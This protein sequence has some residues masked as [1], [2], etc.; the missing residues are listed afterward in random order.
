MEEG[1]EG[2]DGE[3]GEE[4]DAEV[5]VAV[6]LAGGV[7]DFAVMTAR[8]LFLSYEATLSDDFRAT[9]PAF[10]A[11]WVATAVGAAPPNGACTTASWSGVEVAA[12]V[13][14]AAAATSASGDELAEQPVVSRAATVTD[15]SRACLV[16]LCTRGGPRDRVARSTGRG[17]GVGSRARLTARLVTLQ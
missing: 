8:P 5:G 3:E 17:T 6:P 16:S 15:A 2:E 7:T 14:A 9:L 10:A 12:G 13:S 11:S 4:G 1:D